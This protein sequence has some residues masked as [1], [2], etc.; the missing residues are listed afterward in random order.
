MPVVCP[1]TVPYSSCI[2]VCLFWIRTQS[3][4]DVCVCSDNSMCNC[5]TKTVSVTL[6]KKLHL[7]CMTWEAGLLFT[8]TVGAL[9][10]QTVSVDTKL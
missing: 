3:V 8:C 10:L 9:G 2:H 1:M 7:Q 6:K 5:F 4:V